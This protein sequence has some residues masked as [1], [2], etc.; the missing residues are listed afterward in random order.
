MGKHYPMANSVPAHMNE[1]RLNKSI[2]RENL[3]GLANN[4]KWN[5]FITAMRDREDWLPSYRTKAV[6]G[7]ISEWDVE[8]I[9]HLP[10]PFKLVKWFDVDCCQTK[11]TGGVLL[12]DEMI[13]HSEE[14][15]SL[16]EKIG[17]VYEKR[18]GILRI[19]GYGPKDYEAFGE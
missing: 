3:T 8:W 11:E 5:E 18:G 7:Y 12:D 2:R 15:V 16:V 1:E 4:T 6:N 19:F 17:F 10:F 14:F 9:Y 13:D